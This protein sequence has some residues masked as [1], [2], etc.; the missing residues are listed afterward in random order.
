[1]QPS[2]LQQSLMTAMQHQQANRL[3]EAEKLY[4]QIL[5]QHPNSADALHLLGVLSAQLGRH[6]EGV[7]LIRQAIANRPTV[8]G[9]HSNLGHALF[10][11]K[12]FEE[13]ADA[14]REAAKLNP[15]D[16]DIQKD[17]GISLKELGR[18]EEAL[19][20]ARDALTLNPK[21]AKA[22]Y[23]MGTIFQSQ[24]DLDAASDAYRRAGDLEP[25]SAPAQNDLGNAFRS[26]GRHDDAIAHYRR[27]LTIQPNFP[28]AVSA[29]ADVLLEAGRMDEAIAEYQKAI[30]LRPQKAENYND[31]AVALR[32][33]RRFDEALA[34]IDKALALHPNSA[35]FWCN[36]GGLLRDLRR[37]QDAVASIRRALQLDPNLFAAHL[38]L[39]TTLLELGKI[40]QAM[41][42][43][44]KSVELDPRSSEA[45][46]ILASLFKESGQIEN[47]IDEFDRAL[48]ID[49]GNAIVRS[50]KV[51]SLEFDLRCDAA[52][53]FA[54]ARLWNE[55]HALPFEKSIRRHENNR[56]PDRP[57]RVGYVSPGFCNH[58]E[59]FFVIPL[60]EKHD[61][62][63]YEIHCYSDGS[64]ID[65][66]TERIKAVVH[67][68][69][70]SLGSNNE[71]LADQI[72]RDRIDIL[73]DL[74]MHMTQNRLLMFAQKP[75][76][77][78]VAWLAYPGGTGLDAMDYRISDPW[79]DPPESIA[80][81]AEKTIH[82]PET[83]VCYDPL[84]DIP[85]AT[86]RAEGPIRFGSINNPCKL[87]DPLLRLWSR[88]MQ[89]VSDSHLL[90][91]A[92]DSEHRHRLTEFFRA[93]GIAESRV[94]FFSRSP[95]K[96]YLRLYDQIDI[97]LDPLPYNGI[98]TTCDA[99]WMGVPVVTLTGQTAGGRGAASILANAELKDLIADNPEQFVR[100][101]STLASDAP[102]LADLRKSLR[103]RFTRSPIMDAPRFAKAMEAAYRRMWHAWCNRT[104]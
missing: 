50:N 4:R 23:L 61:R 15:K 62:N 99:L 101:A 32:G 59:S 103:D 63:Q 69:H 70:I 1:M 95:R 66:I 17:L 73:V 104:Q 98:T 38:N 94:G 42:S 76:P 57:L 34:A 92:F 11:S 75:A 39:A 48:E 36:R 9:Y 45:H 31:L 54:E 64:R 65:A 26:M 29:L 74:S 87:N 68:W 37:L 81:Y 58:A 67:V 13:A 20:C 84:C 88:V 56:S 44:R 8:A 86:P 27:T 71:D 25:N 80:R 97:C 10:A 14:Y 22:T 52:K 46:N 90:L 89:A 51:Y 49:P 6:Q 5:A 79:I 43:A 91:L 28:E 21:S 60:L 77:V 41:E 100:L 53:L 85:A 35:L 78:Q 33:R 3:E 96:D 19:S 12:H 47:A 24:G 16:A 93:Q 82:L 83:W 30:V 55:L 40:D 102:R 7:K 2:T 72:R 18:F